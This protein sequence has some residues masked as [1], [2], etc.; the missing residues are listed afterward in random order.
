[1]NKENRS[2]GTRLPCY[3]SGYGA[4]AAVILAI[5]LSVCT[6]SLFSGPVASHPPQLL[7]VRLLP[8]EVTLWGVKATQR[9]LVLGQYSDGLERDVTHRSHFSLSDSRV[10]QVDRAGRVT[11]LA[12]G[13]AVLTAALEGQVAT[14]EV[15]VEGSQ[16]SRPFS[17][18]REIGG[19]FTKR[20]CNTNDCHGSVKGKGGFKLSANAL[21]PREDYQWIVEGGTY[22][23]LSAESAGPKTPRINL[24]EPEKSLLLLKPTFAV[25]HGGG[26][27]FGEDSPDY[28]TIVNWVR[29]GA[30]YGEDSEEQ[31]VKI[32][33]LEVLPQAVV[34]D[35]EGQHQLL[36]R[37][38]LSTGRQ[39]DITEQV[40]YVSNNPEVV[41]VNSE[42]LVQAVET[43]ETA[44]MIRAAGKA[45]SAGFGVI[46]Y[47]IADYP[48]AVHRNFIDK[49]VFAKLRKFNILP[50]EL[51]S[52]AEFL[53]RVC[54][55]VAGTLPPPGRVREFLAS[56]DPDKRDKLIETLLHSP[57]YVDYWTF[58]FSDFLRVSYESGNEIHCQ[59]YAQWI[60][61]SI[62]QNKP[63]D[64]IAGERIAGQG[65]NGPT[66]HYY[67]GSEL[68][69]P[70]DVMAEQVR[71]FFGRRLDCAQCH[72]HPYE[73]WSQDQFWEMTAFFGRVTQLGDLAEGG[74]PT[75][76]DDAAGHGL[77]G[78][79]EKV[80][81]PRTKEKVEP[82]FLDGRPLPESERFHPRSRLREWMISH[83]YFA[84]AIANRIWGYFFGRG[85]VHPVDDF[86]LTN[87]PT[88][89]ELLEAL[90]EDFKTH[91]YNLKHL[92][93][94]IVQSRTYQ[95]SS[96]RNE[97]NRDDRVN[98]SQ[99]LPRPLDAEILLDAIS[100]VT[101]VA[102][103]F[104]VGY[105][106][107]YR[108]LPPGTRAV[109]L[110]QPDFFPSRFLDLHGRP[111]RQMVPERKVEPNLGQALHQL[112]G[113][114]YTSKVSKEGGRIDRLLQSGAS[115]REI[116]EEFC[117]AA[118]SRFPAAEEEAQ[119]EQMIDQG[120]SRQ[121]AL[122][123]M[124]W[125]LIA[126]REF[127]YNH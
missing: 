87:P 100:Q 74:S 76:I 46:A 10:G 113:W 21:Y 52:D 2:F 13:Q 45:I 47:P 119:L 79:G 81:H 4:W 51:S 78:Q 116:I 73:N 85:I 34:L 9:V 28:E 110:A 48:E 15:W 67:N 82:K 120:S 38:H 62:A 118:L 109:H 36:V 107:N 114:T 105:Y 101:G 27:R 6:V 93:R 60:R 98:Y 69:L 31:S 8:E 111:N 66:R 115:N 91:G 88:H 18:A 1:M 7:S 41:K 106:P 112:A 72:N 11:A 25:P 71:V 61:D 17:F 86:R 55:D 40:L 90:A 99:A 127:A 80:T 44:I 117:L 29:Q 108:R 96:S 125:G 103:E 126:S 22:Q 30:P 37:A 32:E 19:I 92:I 56:K 54:L 94:R 124:L 121:T 104:A 122:E 35:R 83:P 102:E 84:Q 59:M 5:T 42:G 123:D 70:A 50:S 49:H 65:Y 63:Y 97:T 64:Q 53:R 43:G 14:R 3:L 57:E 39:E 23:V 26:E 58:R 20:G 68:R 75:I 12:D 89:P 95:L 16:E 24:K 33:R 77:Q